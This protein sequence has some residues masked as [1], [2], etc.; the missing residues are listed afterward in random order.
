[1]PSNLP[2]LRRIRLLLR[3]GRIVAAFI[4]ALAIVAGLWLAF[5]SLD[6]LAAFEAGAR[7]N[8]TILLAG[9]SAIALLYLLVKAVSV[10]AD[11]AAMAADDALGDPRRP[12][13]T[14]L[15]LSETTADSPLA[16]H[17]MD[18]TME[19]N[20]DKLRSLPAKHILP[21]KSLRTA[22]FILA[23]PLAIIAVSRIAAPHAFST[24]ANR[25]LHP[26]A[27][28]PPYSPLRFEIDPTEPST[29]YGG[30]I[31]I[32]AKITGG[33]LEHPVE[34]LVREKTGGN[35]LR[36]PAFRES[37]SHFSRKLDGLTSPIEIAF[38]C[39]KARSI[40]YP[41]SL[42]Y[43][44]NVLS[45]RVKITPPSYTRLAP[46]EV[47]LDTNEIKAIEGSEVTLEL[48]S[49]RP[50]SGGTLVFTP[51]ALPGVTSIAQSFPGSASGDRATFTW[52]ATTSGRLSATIRDVRG[53]P[54]AQ[55]LELSFKLLPDQPPTV[56]MTSPPRMIFAT[57]KSVIPIA[58]NAK[59]DFAL[60][61]LQFVRTLTGFRDRIRMV[62]PAL[63][64][65]A[66]DFEDKLDLGTLGLESGQTVELM[67]EAS[68]HNPSLLGHG[69]SEIARVRIISETQY[70][71]YIRNKTTLAEFSA[72]F[73]AVREVLDK[74]RESLEKLLQSSTEENLKASRE[75]HQQAA[76]LL[77]KIAADFPA[78]EIEKRLQDI[79]RQQA[80]DIRENL[81]QL[82]KPPTDEQLRELIDRLGRRQEQAKRL[83]QDIE[84]I[85]QMASL[86]EMAAKYRQIYDSQVSLSKRFGTILDEIRHSQDQNRRLLPSL[87]ETQEKNEA[88]LTAFKS[89]LRRRAEALQ[90]HPQL[91]SFAASSLKFLEDLD[92]GAPETLMNSAAKHGA[93]GNAVDA[94]SNA[95]L[96]RA[97]LERVMSK[98]EPFQQACQGKCQSPFGTRP[99]VNE[100]LAQMLSALMCQNPGSTPNDGLGAGG[101]GSGGFGDSG[102]A[103]NG[104]STEL[105]VVGPER[106]H[107]D[108]IPG[109]TSN[110]DGKGA[111][112]KAGP[113]PAEAGAGML[114]STGTRQGESSSVPP[115]SVPEP[116]R[117]AVKRY[118]TP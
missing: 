13:T 116:Y 40:W 46:S 16:R 56:E 64:T 117:E 99:G 59:D 48:T 61:R 112:A 82:D 114:K 113:L 106:L 87:A 23:A 47:P 37:S 60:S 70:A 110:S 79:A 107:F 41:V 6:V 86:Q 98:P 75:A 83:D 14:A 97:V 8:I 108:P 109:Q 10:S 102:T 66:Y 5:G 12:A 111:G 52:K 90:D 4:A 103:M 57:P 27:D 69:S 91:G 44:P 65:T 22:L 118:F 26:A 95:E 54:S 104:F 96:A 55:P 38:S 94:F 29:V 42:L 92:T 67:V 33:Q 73:R 74:A 77:E 20:T 35:V 100:T 9:I 45:G 71:E 50:L 115:E 93:S 28:L 18:R 105:P 19:A 7:K 24:I 43:E 15:S 32:R 76:D 101:M 21:W 81:A 1:M 2:A 53:T 31:L 34:C 58:A 78:F 62:A 80:S 30:E 85:R 89:E 36:L 17:L 68:D 3:S 84:L 63:T 49:N 39:G 72:R 51:I 88:A 11:Q 25:L